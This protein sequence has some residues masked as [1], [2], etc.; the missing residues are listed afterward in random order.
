MKALRASS[1]VQASA[2]TIAD[3]TGQDPRFAIN[4]GLLHRLHPQDAA[5]WR[6]RTAP[7]SVECL[8]SP[9]L[10]RPRPRCAGLDRG[11]DADLGTHAPDDVYEAVRAQFTEAETVNL[12][13]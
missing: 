9:A 13:C 4:A 11:G 2:S 10:H 12:T 3:R 1:Q 5:T 6:D 8:E 7:L